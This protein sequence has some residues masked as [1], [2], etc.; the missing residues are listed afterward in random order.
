VSSK[1]KP[2]GLRPVSWLVKQIQTALR[3]ATEEALAPVDLTAAQA[4][5][6]SALAYDSHL[7]NAELARAGFVTPQS[8]V[9]LLKSLEIRGLIVR[10]PHPS[11]GRAMP[12]E[13]TPQGAKQL[14][15]VH[16]AMREVEQRLLH[17]LEPAERTRLRELLE[18]CVSS[19]RR[20]R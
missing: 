4:A 9:E 11:G 13:L 8:M 18:R 16:M 3:V 2:P 15:A 10:R 17:D 7:S 19:L 20:E 12:A 5:V 14:L 1:I 6:L